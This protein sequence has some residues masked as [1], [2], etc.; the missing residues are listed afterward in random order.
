MQDEKLLPTCYPFNLTGVFQLAKDAIR[1]S[2]GVGSHPVL[3]GFK[4]SFAEGGWNRL[5]TT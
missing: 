3:Y 1:N 4:L 5:Q 2:V